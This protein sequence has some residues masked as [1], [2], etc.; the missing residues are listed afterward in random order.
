MSNQPIKCKACGKAVAYSDTRAYR[1]E[2]CPKCFE[3]IV[4][5]NLRKMFQR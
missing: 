5:A 2:L 4:A 3:K 1:E